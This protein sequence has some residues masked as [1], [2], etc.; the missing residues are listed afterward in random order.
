MQEKKT[1]SFNQ[2]I[3]RI[4]NKNKGRYGSPNIHF[5]MKKQGYNLSKKRVQILMREMNLYAITIKTQTLF[6][7]QGCRRIRKHFEAGFTTKTINEKWVG[8]ITY[9]HTL[10]DGWIY[11]A[12]VLDLHSKKGCAYDNACIESFHAS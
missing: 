12:S 9:V 6:A 8:D 4:Y 2:E 7:K 3:L 11:L 1:K 10:K 5:I